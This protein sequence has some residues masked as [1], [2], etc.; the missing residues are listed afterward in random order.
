[1][2]RYELKFLIESKHL[3]AVKAHLKAI[4]THIKTY[5][6]SSVYFDNYKLSDY[7]AKSDGDF[8][9]KKIRLR[10]YNSV[11][12]PDEIIYLEHKKRTGELSGKTREILSWQEFQEAMNCRSRHPLLHGL[13]P[14][15]IISYTRTVHENQALRMTLDESLSFARPFQSRVLSKYNVLE[16]KSAQPLSRNGLDWLDRFTKVQSFSKYA[17]AME[18]LNSRLRHG[19]V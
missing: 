6:V 9:K 1:M 14:Q 17:V 7:H 3:A 4:S 2:E 19:Q 18:H 15:V 5:P 12:S 10:T 13:F 11:H 8:Y 16:L